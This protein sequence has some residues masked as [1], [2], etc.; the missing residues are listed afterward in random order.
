MVDLLGFILLS[1]NVIND[2]KMKKS[3][4]LIIEEILR[5]LK[6]KVELEYKKGLIRFFKEKIN[7][8]GVRSKET[9]I[10]SGKYFQKIKCL[11]KKDIWLLCD[12]LLKLGFM[13]TSMIAFDWA[14][15]LRRD[16]DYQ[17]FKLFE[18][19]LKRDVTS[20]A[21]CD[22][23]GTHALGA[24][25]FKYPNFYSKTLVWAKSRSRWQRRMAAVNLIYAV[26]Q[27]NKTVLKK[28]F[29]IS[30]ILLLDEDDLVQKGYGWLL[31]EAAN[32]WQKEV[33]EFVMKHKKSMPRT[34]L[35]YA[36]EKMPKKM[37]E[38][39]MAK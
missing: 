13:E 39:A 18:K 27:R 35:R 14:F 22:V 17:D 7:P 23:F 36:I 16:Y 5:D 4:R 37:K 6:K 34:A 38:K 8:L 19:W 3:S 21:H 33:F 32:F 11:E 12:E 10:I 28:V 29:E 2:K 30:K 15:R 1:I 20:W 25:I 26:K 24:L 9:K 31:K